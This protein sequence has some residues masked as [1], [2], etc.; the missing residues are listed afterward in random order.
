MSARRGDDF[1]VLAYRL[2]LRAYPAA[3]RAS[4]GP[5]MTQLFRDQLRD[6]R[7]TGGAPARVGFWAAV[8]WDVARSAP[9]LRLEAARARWSARQRG[10]QHGGPHLQPEGGTMTAKRTMAVVTVLAGAFE[11]ANTGAEV[12]AG[13]DG[14]SG[15]GWQ[16]A[17]VLAALMG[18][19]L[20]TAG[21][22]LLRRGPGPERAARAAALACL[23]L[24]VTL[25]FTFPFMSIF[26]RLLGVGVPLALLFVTRRR[27]PSVPVAA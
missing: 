5:E 7:R 6:R 14:R 10:P 18:A 21:I 25:Q 27:D 15:D 8:L 24:V 2:L 23:A 19:L 20:L 26:S 4:Y 3:F 12:W 22:A 1:G 17:M 13:R 11:L 9:V 16:L